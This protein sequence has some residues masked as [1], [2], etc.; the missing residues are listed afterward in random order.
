MQV[1]THTH[2]I[3]EMLKAMAQQGWRIT[4]QRRSLAT[5]FAESGSYLSPKDVYEYMK[6]KYPGV[7][8]DT[9]YRNLR[10]LSEMGVLEQFHLADGL[11]FKASCLSH[12]H[13]H[14]ICVGCEKTVTFEF[15]PMKLVK[16]L[17]ESFEIQSHRFEIFGYCS[18]CKSSAAAAAPIEH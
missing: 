12:H 1:G 4:E 17:P 6:V 5:L 15:C 8:F 10:L 14:M 13:H 2:T 3:D 9:V 11:K 7:S 16:D 18:E